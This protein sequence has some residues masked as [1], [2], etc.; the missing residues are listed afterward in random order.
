MMF[1]RCRV[2][3]ALLLTLLS[4]GA[5]HAALRADT[6]EN[7]AFAAAMRSFN[8]HFFDRAEKELGE[9]ATRYA[10]NAHVPEAI[11]LRAQAH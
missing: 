7:D 3:I 2:L 8:D 4:G 10:T 9:F 1:V 5:F 6:P 11:L